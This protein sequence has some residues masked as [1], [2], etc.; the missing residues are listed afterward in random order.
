MRPAHWKIMAIAWT[1]LLFSAADWP[2]W[3]GPNRDGISK[4]AGLQREWPASG[5][6][7]VWRIDNLGGGYSTPSVVGDRLYLITSNDADEEFV[8]ALSVEDGREIWTTPLGKVGPNEGPQY[9]GSRS[10][11]T[12]DGDRLY[13]LSSNGDL[14]CIEL[15]TGKIR[16]KR[17]IRTDLGGQPGNWA[18]SESPLIDGDRLICTPGGSEATLVAFDKNTG[19]IVWKSAVPGGDEAAYASPIIVN[20]V[21]IKQYVQFLQNGLVGVD[22]KDGKFLW[23]YSRTAEGSPANIPTPVAKDDLIYSAASRSGG[24][25]IR[26]VKTGDEVAAE[27]VYFRPNLPKSIGGAVLVDGFLYGT[28]GQGLSCVEFATGEIRW[29][30]RS[31]GAGS[32]CYADGRLYLHG[33][34]GELALVEAT[35]EAY[36]EV[37]RFTPDGQPDRGNAKA[38]TYPV[39]A[40]GRLYV[41]DLGVL[42]CYDVSG[43]E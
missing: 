11:P 35:P 27:E 32:L 29:Q 10:T 19:D 41:H 21:G 28:S 20:A 26:I 33:E 15:E 23:R 31:V 34:N 7:L 2:Q 40:N 43:R 1:F 8:K 6:K 5:P 3:R 25:L 9:P 14:A 24:G 36:R 37:G 42:W 22:A 30:D 13:A 39:V 16:W 4:E 18:Y 38:W 17:N 12:I